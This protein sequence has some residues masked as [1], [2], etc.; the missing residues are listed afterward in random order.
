M[1][2]PELTE[3]AG[4]RCT[5]W[6]GELARRILGSKDH[7]VLAAESLY[8]DFREML[9]LSL[10]NKL[11]CTNERQVAAYS[12]HP[13]LTLLTRKER[14]SEAH[15]NVYPRKTSILDVNNSY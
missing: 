10:S 12:V 15:S 5:H 3:I 14:R 1:L 7:R 11:K 13:P 2:K 8:G 4:A 9:P 6:A